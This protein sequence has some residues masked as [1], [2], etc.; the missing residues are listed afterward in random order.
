MALPGETIVTE[1]LSWLVGAGKWF[2]GDVIDAVRH[3]CARDGRDFA[4]VSAT[5]NSKTCPCCGEALVPDSS[6][7]SSCECGWS[8]NRDLSACAV[9][10]RKFF[11]FKR[12]QSRLA[13]VS[14]GIPRRERVKSLAR[15]VSFRGSGVLVECGVRVGVVS[16]RAVVRGLSRPVLSGVF[17]VG[18]LDFL[19]GFLESC[20]AG[21]VFLVP[22]QCA[23]FECGNPVDGIVAIDDK[24]NHGYGNHRS[25]YHLRY[26][27]I[28]S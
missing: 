19:V 23:E 15:P 27:T 4:I 8:A 5:R 21:T 7:L 28:P 14:R 11:K 20:V 10:G 6:R 3:A 18:F 16:R 25:K 24:I 26:N 12:G 1:D 2:F 22:K 13:R 17:L 9:M